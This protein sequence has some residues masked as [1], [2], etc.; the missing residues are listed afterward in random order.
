MT[1]G[2]LE[3]SGISSPVLIRRDKYG[4]PYVEADNDDD[5]WYGLG[6]CQGQDR[7]FQIEVFLRTV[8]GTVA[9]IVGHEAIPIDRLSRR[10]GFQRVAERQ[11]ECLDDETLRM[12]QAF[13]RGITDG[14]RVGCHRQAHEFTSQA[15]PVFCY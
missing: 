9:E 8:R 14:V 2:T 13:A 4:I 11:L 15:K 10:I 1:S 3:A 6:F 7:A 5:A 12:V